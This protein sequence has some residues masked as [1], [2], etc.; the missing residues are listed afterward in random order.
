[1]R[2]EPKVACARGHPAEPGTVICP[3]CGS[4]V[5]KYGLTEIGRAAEVARE[6]AEYGREPDPLAEDIVRYIE[7]A[8][9]VAQQQEVK[10]LLLTYGRWSWHEEQNR[11]RRAILR[12]V[13]GDINALRDFDFRVPDY[14]DILA[15]HDPA[16][17][18]GPLLPPT[19]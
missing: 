7:A 17:T 12:S 18:M 19:V 2:D 13:G 9:P 6:E 5:A 15:V 10:A 16:N 8:Y 14:R 4:D 1:M 3:T 11:V